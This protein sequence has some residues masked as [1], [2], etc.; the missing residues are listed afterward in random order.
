[1]IV[2]L[3]IL[4]LVW[5]WISLEMYLAPSEKQDKKIHDYENDE[6]AIF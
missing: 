6:E 2:V 4:C 1:M 3:I 5:A